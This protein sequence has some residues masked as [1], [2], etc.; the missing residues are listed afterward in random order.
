M[1]VWACSECECTQADSFVKRYL[2]VPMSQLT[3]ALL[4]RNIHVRKAV[5]ARSLT[6]RR[7]WFWCDRTA[8][9]ATCGASAASHKRC[10]NCCRHIASSRCCASSSGRRRSVHKDCGRCG[11]SRGSHNCSIGRNAWAWS[12]ALASLVWLILGVSSFKFLLPWLIYCTLH[13][14]FK[15]FLFIILSSIFKARIPFDSFLRLCK[16][17]LCLWSNKKTFGWCFT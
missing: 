4:C 10:P 6:W 2:S 11:L 9:R 1:E 5:L 14:W 8:R 15:L 16:Q 17:M 7:K 12:A 3:L 13:S